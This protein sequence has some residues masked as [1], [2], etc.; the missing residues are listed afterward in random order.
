MQDN[1]NSCGWISI[2]FFWVIGD[3]LQPGSHLSVWSFVTDSSGL[4]MAGVVFTKVG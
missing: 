1:S 4:P 2:T 3:G